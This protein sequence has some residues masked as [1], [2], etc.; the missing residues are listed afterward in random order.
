LKLPEDVRKRLAEERNIW[1]ATVRPSGRPHLVPVWFV[2]TG[3]CLYVCIEPES[4]KGRNLQANSNVCLALEGGSHPVICEGEASLAAPPWP[5]EP[6]SLF[7]AKYD[8]DIT[9]ETRYTRLVRVTPRKWL[10]W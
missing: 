3:D 1:I 2:Y 5:E 9:A 4:V 8:W 10:H 6:V 7:R